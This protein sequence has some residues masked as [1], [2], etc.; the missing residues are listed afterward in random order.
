MKQ[1][2]LGKDGPMVGAVGLGCMSFAGFYGESS[3]DDADATL[4]RCKELGVTHLD[5]A[6]VYGMGKSETM[7]GRFLGGDAQGFVIATKAAIRRGD[8]GNRWFCNDPDYMR[9]ELEGSLTRLGLD[10]VDLF[11]AHRRDPSME[12]ETIMEGMLKLVEDGLI[13]GIG[14]SEIAPATLRRA[15]KVGPVRAVQS[16][17]SLWTRFPELGMIQACEEVG[18]AFVPFSSMGRGMFGSK[19]LDRATFP[20]GDFRST[21]P[22]FQSPNFETNLALIAPFRDYATALGTKPATLATAWVLDQGDHLIPIPGTRYADH[23]DELA[24]AASFDLTD[25]IRAEIHRLLPPGFA[26]GDRYSDAQW[27]G[28]EKYG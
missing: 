7:M 25:D 24:E 17:Y 9:S 12:I 13:G 11:Y 16:E 27:V 21:G 10:R 15:A 4:A 5:T 19:P 18:A 8:D 3:Q 26:H 28:I 22:R 2:Q 14:F 6:N 1:R 20:K 23:L